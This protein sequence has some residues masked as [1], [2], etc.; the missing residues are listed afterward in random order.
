MNALTYFIICILLSAIVVAICWQMVFACYITYR[1][2]TLQR[3]EDTM[4]QTDRQSISSHEGKK[5]ESD[6]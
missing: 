5:A 1:R 6:I 3:F 4:D 2:K